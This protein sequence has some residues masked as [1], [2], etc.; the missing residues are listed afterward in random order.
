MEKGSCALMFN[1]TYEALTALEKSLV[2]DSFSRANAATLG[3][4]LDEEAKKTGYPVAFEIVIN[5]LVVFRYFQD[6]CPAESNHWLMRKR[7]VI[8]SQQMSSLR[9]GKLLELRGQTLEDN[10]MN[11][12]EYAP[13]GGGM[14]IILRGTGVIGSVCVSGCPDHL[15]D[16]DIVSKAMLRLLD[17]KS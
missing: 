4:L 1:Y 7:R 12:Q 14:P 9:F 17:Y 2:F 5:G 8:E 11:P 3:A 6:G 15:R 13:G 16:Q 10:L